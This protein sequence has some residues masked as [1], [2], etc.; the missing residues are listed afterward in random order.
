MRLT[1]KGIAVVFQPTG[2]AW[3]EAFDI[4]LHLCGG[5]AVLTDT[6]VMFDPSWARW[7]AVKHATTVLA[8]HVAVRR[9]SRHVRIL[10]VRA[11]VYLSDH[12]YSLYMTGHLP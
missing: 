12:A 11:F 6:L 8:A 1:S 2:K 9:A 10:W 7:A 3:Q 5:V 4:Y